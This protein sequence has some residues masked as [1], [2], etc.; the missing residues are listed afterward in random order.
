MSHLFEPLALR[1]MIIP[2]RV[3]MSPMCMYSAA[4]DGP[5]TGVA[6]D[7]HFAH[8]ASR[9]VGGAGLVVVEA[10]AVNPVGRITPHDLG[11]WNDSQRRALSRITGFLLAQGTV[12]VIQLA[13]A[14][15]K[16][17]TAQP[18]LGGRAVAPEAGG[19]RAVGPSAV[20]FGRYPVPSELTVS[21]IESVVDDFAA[22][23]HRALAA[24]FR[25]VEIHGAHGYLIHSFLSPYSNRRT[26]SYGGSFENRVRFALEVVDAVREVWPAELPLFFRASATD[27]I[28]G[29]WSVDDSVR[30]AGLLKEHGV[31]LMDVSGGGMAPDARIPVGPAYQ[32]PFAA[33]IRAETGLP[34]A[35]VGLITEPKQ[36][37]DIVATGAADAVMLGRELL[38]NPYWP[39]HA[40]R[41]L[42]VEPDWPNQYARAV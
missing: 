37:E 23:A 34:V 30:L 25:A 41:E 2:N 29:G 19:W 36:A 3:W 42:G 38:R 10:T 22:A 14:G 1:S 9:A 13:H 33:R 39:L 40:A 7:F 27:W 26:D 21:E 12:P 17:S 4:A 28:D 32:V 20:P 11:L 16:A 35:A 15:R 31:D 8:L 18:W 6:T 5:G 24:G